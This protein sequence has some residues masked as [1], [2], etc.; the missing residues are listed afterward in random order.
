M[1]IFEVATLCARDD[2]GRGN[3][4]KLSCTHVVLPPEGSRK[5]LSRISALQRR[6]SRSHEDI[7]LI[8]NSHISENSNVLRWVNVRRSAKCD[9]PLVIRPDNRF[10][11]TYIEY[12]ASRR[13]SEKI[14][15]FERIGRDMDHIRIEWAVKFG[16][17]HL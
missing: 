16:A 13:P 2:R 12:C 1:R 6:I 11:A 14:D 5:A 7:Q 4:P 15:T 10:H 17:G 3:T 8:L 9:W